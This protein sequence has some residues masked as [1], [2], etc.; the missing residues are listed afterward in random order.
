MKENALTVGLWFQ[1]DTANGKLFGKDGY[2]AFGKSYKTVSCSLGNGQLRADPARV[3]GGKVD[4]GTWNHA[5]LTA[6]ENV[7]TPE[8]CRN[9]SCSRKILTRTLLGR[10]RSLKC[11][12]SIR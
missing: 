10:Y 1:S 5:V 2:N 11:I 8:S 9:G 12:S 3:G 7:E 6:D 4:P